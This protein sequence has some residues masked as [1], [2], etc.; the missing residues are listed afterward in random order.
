[1]I[2]KTLIIQN[3]LGLHARPASVFVQTSKNF[4]STISVANASKGNGPVDAKSILGVLTLGVVMGDAIALSIDGMDEQEA[5]K[6]LCDLVE[7][8]FGESVKSVGK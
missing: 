2:T 3:K 5:Q 1:M 8:N 7:S 4:K 6:A